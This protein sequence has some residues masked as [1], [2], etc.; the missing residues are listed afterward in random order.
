MVFKINPR[1]CE[2]AYKISQTQFAAGPAALRESVLN[3]S[4]GNRSAKIKLTQSKSS[5]MA[6]PMNQKIK[7]SVTCPHAP[8]LSTLQSII[9]YS[10]QL[11]GLAL[12]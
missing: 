7:N 11:G 2:F 10:T 4:C 6:D 5:L 9:Q 8:S 12:D 1:L 3:I